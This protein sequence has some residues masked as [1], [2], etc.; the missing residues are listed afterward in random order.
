MG[1]LTSGAE[2]RSGGSGNLD[3]AIMP[4]TLLDRL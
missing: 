1:T 2:R 4:S 3:I